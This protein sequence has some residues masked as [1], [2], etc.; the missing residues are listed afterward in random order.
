MA[1]A[2]ATAADVAAGFRTLDADEQER[3]AALLLEAAVLIDAA[4]PEAED[5]A[6]RVVSC[7]MVR[8]ALGDGDD[9]SVLGAPMGAMQGAFAAGGYS[10]SWTVGS[11]GAVGELY[12]SKADRLMLGIGNRIGAHSPLEA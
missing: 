11:G 12:L 1:T 9:Y 6:R 10:Q 7:R 5:D 4:A 3:A 2:Y 8:R